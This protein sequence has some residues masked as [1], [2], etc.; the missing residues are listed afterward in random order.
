MI[1]RITVMAFALVFAALCL[2]PASAPAEDGAKVIRV[3][4]YETPFNH[5]DSFGR[6]TGY[7]Y[8]YQRKIA[9]YTGWT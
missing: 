8:E 5:K 4:W 7:A 9:A 1:R 2:L 6:R 3:G